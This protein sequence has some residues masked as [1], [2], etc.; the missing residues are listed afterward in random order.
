MID[1]RSDAVTQPTD[2]M[3]EAM[4][5]APPHWSA[6]GDDPSVLA[7]E[8]RA[9]ALTGMESA[10]FVPTGTMANLLALMGTVERGAQV[11]LEESSHILWSEEWSLS[12]ICGAHPRPI[13]G[14]AGVIDP[15]ALRHALR[16]RRFSH[17]PQTALIC[18]EN[19]HNA[20]GG[21]VL[22][23]EQQAALVAVAREYGVP[24]HVDG[25]RLFNAQVALGMSLRELLMG[26]DSVALSLSKGL[27]APSGAL[28]CGSAALIERSRINLKRLGAH[29][30]TNAGIQAAAGLVA[31]DTML[32]QLREDHRRARLLAEGL[33]GLPG[34]ALDLERVQTNVVMVRLTGRLNAVQL[35]E[36]L[37]QRGI[38]T[39]TYSD[40]MLR[41][42]LHRH[43]DD[44]MVAQTIAVCTELLNA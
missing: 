6:G 13:A 25:A 23:P 32:P 42:V 29:S 19:T 18:L 36:Q 41:L 31:L 39:V 40:E 44:A 4:R 15:D 37:A 22:R 33:A 8:A 30:L 27:S 16:E 12:Y 3:W 17:R 24:V 5:A 43:I 10:L 21:T 35:A 26:V 34:L 9:V 28:L 2:A 7:L 11:I 20:A 1:L 14:T 38:R